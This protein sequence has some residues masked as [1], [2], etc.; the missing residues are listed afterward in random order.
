[1]RVGLVVPCKDEAA[2]LDAEAFLAAVDTHPWLDLLFVDDGSTDATGD[3]LSRLAAARPERIR[4]LH[5]PQ[6]RGKGE[7]VRFGLNR[8]LE[9]IPD[10]SDHAVGYW[11]ADLATPLED[12][13]RFREAMVAE[14]LDGVLGARIK[15]LGKA[16]RRRAWRHWAGRVAATLASELLDLPVYDTQCGAKLFRATPALRALLTEPFRSRWAFDVEL[17]VRWRRL[18]PDL[19]DDDLHHALMEL[20]VSRWAEVPGSKVT[21]R[22]AVV[23]P[24]VLLAIR[25]DTRPHGPLTQRLTRA[26]VSRPSPSPT[27]SPPTPDHTT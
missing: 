3:V 18:H 22:D 1:M 6:N 24:A 11:D 26:L 7:A 13:A 23:T 12:V 15:M 19:G 9:A 8:A 16:V 14:G 5:L 17:L 21:L 4:H 27:P 2:R 10:G 25:W 20:P